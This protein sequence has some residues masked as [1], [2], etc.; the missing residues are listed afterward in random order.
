MQTAPQTARD[1]ARLARRKRNLRLRADA[2]A[3]IRTFFT[4][5][6]YLEVETPCRIPAPAPE[7]HIEA[8]AAGDWF[9]QP[10]PELCM[11]RM[12]AAGYE[13][14]FQI[15]KCFRGR[16]R[17]RRHLP[18]LTLLE[19]Y[20]AGHSYRDMM[21][22]SEELIPFVAAA[23]LGG[24][25]LDVGGVSVSLEAPWER[26]PVSEAF[27]RYA[28]AS[29]EAALADGRFDEV[30]G[31]E[32][33]PRLGWDTPVL[34][35]DYPASM[36]SLA[37]LKPPGGRLAERFELYI[38]GVELCNAFGELTDPAE[39]RRRFEAERDLRRAAGRAVTPMP[40]RFLQSLSAMPAA[41]GNAL[42]IDRLVMLL[43]GA[44]AVDE[45]VAFTPE[46]L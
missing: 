3:A 9:L 14:I 19:W 43:A 42:G 36:G 6:G 24:T 45:V 7:A 30:M 15:C 26:L 44:D 27:E 16:E 4:A 34:L 1:L 37:R 2:I 46:E 5:S 18:E 11:K 13:K 41:A 28:A 10:S 32:I 8:V 38:G 20:T 35:Y 25:T 22:Q 21:A 31:C 39:Q 23:A 17:G 29:M 40:E 12:L 33:E